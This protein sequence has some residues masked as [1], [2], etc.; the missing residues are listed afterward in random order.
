VLSSTTNRERLQ[1][2]FYDS[3][4]CILVTMMN[5]G[6]DLIEGSWYRVSGILK[7]YLLSPIFLCS[8]TMSQLKRQAVRGYARA[9]RSCLDVLCAISSAPFFGSCVSSS[10]NSLGCRCRLLL[11]LVS[12]VRLF[13]SADSVLSSTSRFPLF[14]LSCCLLILLRLFPRALI[15][16]QV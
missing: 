16:I 15:S 3:S 2:L 7:S 9:S 11:L 12:D 13:F 6:D 5:G 1:V 14:V 10:M 4:S 8:C